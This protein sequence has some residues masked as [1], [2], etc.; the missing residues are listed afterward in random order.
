M[1]QISIYSER[2]LIMLYTNLHIYA[3]ALFNQNMELNITK[4]L[5]QSLVTKRKL[6]LSRQHNLTDTSILDDL[7]FFTLSE[8]L[9]EIFLLIEDSEEVELLLHAKSYITILEN[10]QTFPVDSKKLLYILE[11]LTKPPI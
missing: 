5:Y 11:K 2:K 1:I 8:W 6:Y 3:L 7:F 10:N 9:D 4:T